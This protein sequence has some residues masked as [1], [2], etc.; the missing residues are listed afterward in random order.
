M[1]Q[2]DVN[3]LLAQMRSL[4]TQMDLPDAART[5]GA[6][7]TGG[8]GFGEL[9]KQS[10]DEVA[11]AQN[12]ASAQMKAFDS[13]DPNTDLSQVMI[14]MQKAGLSFQA[15]TEVRNKLVDAYKQIMNMSV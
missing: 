6:K 15:M 1:S 3:S 9:L 5:T 12:T 2:I 13:G 4:S 7:S 14:S 10:I 11:K 8:T